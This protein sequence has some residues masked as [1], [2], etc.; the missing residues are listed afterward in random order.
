MKTR[1]IYFIG[2][3]LL[4][5]GLIAYVAQRQRLS[6]GAAGKAVPDSAGS[7]KGKGRLEDHRDVV[8]RISTLQPTNG[9]TPGLAKL[10]SFELLNNG[11]SPLMCPDAWSLEF[12]DGSV[13]QLAVPGSGN[14]R[15]QPG[16][17][18]TIA[19]TNPLT[20][21]SWRLVANYYFEDVVFDVKVKID[22]SALKH[23]LPRSVSSVRGQNV[24]S[25]WIK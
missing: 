11:S 2:L 14:I 6:N 18:G 13:Q 19:I 1:L 16:G 10:V 25:D 3:T 21:R 17:K 7:A 8:L 22:Q 23:V 5:V 4:A 15:V 12:D 24:M 9:V 20:M